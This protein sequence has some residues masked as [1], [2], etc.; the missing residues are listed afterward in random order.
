MAG[1]PRRSSVL[2]KEPRS[3]YNESRRH[4]MFPALMRSEV[5][6]RAVFIRSEG[7]EKSPMYRTSMNTAP[8]PLGVVAGFKAGRY[9]RDVL[10]LRSLG[11]LAMLLLSPALLPVPVVPDEWGRLMPLLATAAV[12]QERAGQTTDP[13]KTPG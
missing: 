11:F 3:H 2:V 4:S 12:A 6:P 8:R 5:T 10:T 1:M 13:Q 9:V 7:L